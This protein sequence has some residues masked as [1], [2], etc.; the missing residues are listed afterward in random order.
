MHSVRAEK[1][2]VANLLRACEP[3]VDH[4]RVFPINEGRASGPG[5]GVGN[6]GLTLKSTS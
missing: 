1:L 5:A 3:R 6:I 4:V 2:V